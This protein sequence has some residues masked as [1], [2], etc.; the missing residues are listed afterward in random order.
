MLFSL[1][2]NVDA[3]L[4]NRS[5]FF[6]NRDLAVTLERLSSGVQINHGADNPHGLGMSES[7]RARVRGIDVALQNGQ[8]T[9]GFLNAR[10]SYM[11]VQGNMLNRMLELAVRAS[12]GAT[13]TD[14]DLD[15]LNDEAQ[16]LV[17]EF[18]NIGQT[19]AL[20]GKDGSSSTPSTLLLWHPG[21]LD[22]VWVFDRTGSMNQYIAQASAVAQTMFDQFEAKKFD[23]QMA[24]VGFDGWIGAYPG[25]PGIAVTLGQFDAAPA[26]QTI[27]ITNGFTL[28]DNAAAFSAQAG[29]VTTA[30]SNANEQGMDAVVEAL[31]KF[32]PAFSARPDAQRVILLITDADSDDQGRA[33]PVYDVDAATESQ[34]TAALNTYDAILIYAGNQNEN[35]IPI[36]TQEQD[37]VNVASGGS[38]YLDDR[39]NAGGGPIVPGTAWVNS[40]VNSLLAFGGNYS[41]DFHIGPDNSAGSR[42]NLAFKTVDAKTTKIENV[43]L[44][45]VGN[46][47]TSIDTIKNAIEYVAQERGRTGTHVNRLQSIINDYTDERINVA[48]ARSR[49]TDTDMAVSATDMAKQ[50]IVQN[51]AMAMS[52]SANSSPAA[53]LDL[54]STND[55][56]SRSLLQQGG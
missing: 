48:A 8:D 56:G 46:A 1:N 45:S 44:T 9:I 29:L 42:I 41:L 55:I 17:A 11:E 33:G 30:G 3:L 32:T 27:D 10:D 18:H 13:L 26:Q 40:V 20:R 28:V 34:V 12:N 25:P 16:A 15:K 22:V 31:E 50:Q 36:G 43:D 38:V 2:T 35:G 21:E 24:A 53:V 37:Y 52:S 47:Q 14:R 7:M 5:Q 51:S 39:I 54:L 49:I 4:N 23:L 6:S 19:A